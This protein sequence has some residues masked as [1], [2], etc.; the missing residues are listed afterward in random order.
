MFFPCTE[1][2]ETSIPGRYT[3]SFFVRVRMRSG[4]MACV[5]R[6]LH[7]IGL[8]FHRSSLHPQLFCLLHGYLNTRC[9]CTRNTCQEVQLFIVVKYTMSFRPVLMRSEHLRAYSAMSV[10]PFLGF[11]L[12]D[13]RHFRCPHAKILCFVCQ[14]QDLHFWSQ[15]VFCC[16]IGQ[17]TPTPFFS[18]IISVTC[19]SPNIILSN[20]YN[21]GR[22]ILR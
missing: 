20:R 3:A 5:I 1:K 18:G 10:K 4:S 7:N 9:R 15:M 22:G 12:L 21:W 13:F 6:R 2:N 17:N 11:S 8:S 19:V 14:S 16:E